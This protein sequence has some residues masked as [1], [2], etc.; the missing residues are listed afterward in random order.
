MH[1]QV[2]EEE[3]THCFLQRPHL[4]GSCNNNTQEVSITIVFR[5]FTP[6]PGGMEFEPGRTYYFITTS[7]GTLSGIDRR[8]DGL[9]SDRQMKVK[10]EVQLPRHELPNANPK[11]AAR[12]SQ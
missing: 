5:Q 8:K 7:D 2:S 3:Y 10:F 12:T 11:F 1:F 6:T 9:C 4:V